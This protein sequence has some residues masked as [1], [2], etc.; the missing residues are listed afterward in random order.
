[1]TT[2]TIKKD[3]KLNKLNFNDIDELLEAILFSYPKIVLNEIE[4]HD[5]PESSKELIKKSK[6]LGKED[7]YNF[8][9]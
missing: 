1:M 9:L 4:Y 5:L 2:L 3:I 6:S 7:L 8:Q